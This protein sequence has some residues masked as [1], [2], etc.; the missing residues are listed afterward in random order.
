MIRYIVKFLGADGAWVEREFPNKRRAKKFG[1]AHA[2]L[3]MLWT[4]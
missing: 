1:R 3:F 2:D 4:E